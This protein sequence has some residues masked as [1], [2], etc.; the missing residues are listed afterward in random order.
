MAE[1]PLALVGVV[2]PHTGDW[3]GVLPEVA[4]LVPVAHYDPHPRV[5]Q[6]MLRP[7]YDRLPV[8]GDLKELLSHHRVQAALVLLPLSEAEEALLTL[9]RAGVHVMAEKPVARTAGALRQVQAAA[10]SGTAFYAGYCWRWDAIV[11]QIRSL[12]SEGMLGDLWSIEMRWI[13]SKVGRR[14]GIPAHRDPAHFLFRQE[15]SRG[16]MLEWL[17]CHWVD[18]MLYITGQPVASVMAMT[19]RQTNDEI[20]V[21]DT[22]VCLLRFANGMLGSL[23]TGYLLPEGGQTCLCLRGSLGWVQW[24]WQQGRRFVAHSEHP[25]WN[26]SPTRTYDFP[27]PARA[28]YGG[29]TGAAMLRDFARCIVEGSANPAM[30]VADCVRVLDVIDAAYESAA[31][32]R[33]VAV[34]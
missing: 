26:A 3:H 22:A 33:V 10:G 15:I 17:G 23:H 7:P 32:G 4:Q 27:L 1:I 2:H 14:A 13:T 19:A 8:Y 34:A 25:S 18:L 9:V 5:A 16:G 21:E 30:T 11:N 29:G 20:E 24:D 12:V 31:S 6:A 28:S